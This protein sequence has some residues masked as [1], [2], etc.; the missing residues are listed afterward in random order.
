MKF[1]RQHEDKTIPG[2]ITISKKTESYFRKKVD[3]IP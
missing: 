3:G 2:L 1:F